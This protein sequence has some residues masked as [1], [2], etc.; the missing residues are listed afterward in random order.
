[1]S[2]LL[3]ILVVA[4]LS[5]CAWLTPTA[6]FDT[7]E[8]DKLNQIYTDAGLF[9]KDC[10]DQT[11]T[12]ANFGKLLAQ[13]KS[14]VNY[15]ADLPHNDITIGMVNSLDKVIDSGNQTYQDGK[16]HSKTFCE[17]KLEGV[18]KAAGTIKASVAQRRRP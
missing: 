6:P 9:K 11:Q 4:T 3:S 13:S 2:K 8:Y 17:L 5:G 7:A 12:I 1:M 18:I 16:T 10:A 15:S 14:L